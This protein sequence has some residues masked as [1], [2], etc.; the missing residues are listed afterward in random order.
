VALD[1]E[2]LALLLEREPIDVV[3]QGDGLISAEVIM[4]SCVIFADCVIG[5]DDVTTLS[6]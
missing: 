3:D 1:E 4:Y 2:D 6:G 5:A